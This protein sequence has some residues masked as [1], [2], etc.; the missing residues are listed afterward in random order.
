MKL[1]KK[2]SMDLN[3]STLL[4][5]DVK[6]IKIAYYIITDLNILKLFFNSI[7]QYKTSYIKLTL[8]VQ[9]NCF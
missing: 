1:K 9:N 5:M 7:Q 3:I 6:T 8:I 2:N 4:L